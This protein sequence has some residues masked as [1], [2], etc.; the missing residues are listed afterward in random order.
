[1]P[2]LTTHSNSKRSLSRAQLPDDAILDRL[3][4]RCVNRTDASLRASQEPKR[5]P[6]R[7]VASQPIRIL[8][9]C[10]PGYFQHLGVLLTSL[11]QHNRGTFFDVV[12]VSRTPPGQDEAKLRRSIDSYDN[13]RLTVQVF[14]PP[15]DMR[16]PLRVHYTIDTYT[17]LWVA[18]FFPPDVERI[19]YLDCDMIVTG[20]I[21]ELWQ[22][23]LGGNTIGAV[24]IPGSARSE[25]LEIPEQFGYFNAGVMLIDLPRWRA[26]RTFDRIIEF[27]RHN[28]HKLRDADQDALNAC[29]Y[30]ERKPLSYVWNVI[31]LFYYREGH[32]FGLS[33][34]VLDEIV[35]N[36]KIV[37]FN[38]AWKPWMYMDIH[39]RKQDYYEYLKMTEWRDYQPPD[40]TF[41][42]YLEK[43]HA[44][45][46]P[47]GL[48]R[49]IRAGQ[50]YLS[51]RRAMAGEDK[52][53]DHAQWTP[54]LRPGA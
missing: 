21:A 22:T 37:H 9:C 41:F 48:K 49:A 35:T 33:D 28:S 17:R 1:M 24:S 16:L 14:H 4:N 2:A 32:Q 20:D 5:E 36:A 6:E 51:N 42:N 40:K 39:P 30:G 50:R 8:L 34:A 23:D 43:H 54:E 12:L 52:G 15:S 13:C 3:G 11:L 44:H 7:V 18:D 53:A 45:L 46:L 38:G 19:L 26:T 27:I 29:L 25:A 47:R 31:S 10:D